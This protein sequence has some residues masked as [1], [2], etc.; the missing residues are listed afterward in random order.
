MSKL[1]KR[2]SYHTP[3][4]VRLPSATMFLSFLYVGFDNEIRLFVSNQGWVALSI[5]CLTIKCGMLLG[6]LGQASILPIT[7]HVERI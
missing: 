2:Y 5:I 6:F 7:D 3:S 1:C 4:V